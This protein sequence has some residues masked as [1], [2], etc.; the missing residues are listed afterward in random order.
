MSFTAYIPLGFAALW[1][2]IAIAIIV[3]PIS[4]IR[5]RR[6]LAF[7]AG[8]KAF[9][10]AQPSSSNPHACGTDLHKRWAEGWDWEDFGSLYD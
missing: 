10:R 3:C 8:R 2:A 1:L 7:R 5:L 6:W 9:R 4:W